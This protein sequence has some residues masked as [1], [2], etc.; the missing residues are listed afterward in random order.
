M[1]KTYLDI[2]GQKID[3]EAHLSKSRTLI[4]LGRDLPEVAHNVIALQ[5]EAM[6]VFQ[7]QFSRTAEED[8]KLQNGQWRTDC[9]KGILSRLQHA[10]SLCM[11]RC[12]NTHPARPTYQ[13]RLPQK[14]TRLNGQELGTEGALL[15]DGDQI[16][17]GTQRIAVVRF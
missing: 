8:W 6:D 17:A 15:R 11:G 13:W 16:E 2:G 1:P 3:L 9:P 12:V 14:P 5:D 4:T 7:C 10:C